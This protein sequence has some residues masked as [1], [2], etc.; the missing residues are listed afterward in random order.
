MPR[1]SSARRGA[2]TVLL[3]TV[4]LGVAGAEVG[5]RIMQ[6]IPSEKLLPFPSMTYLDGPSAETPTEGYTRF[7]PELGWSIG[8]SAQAVNDGIVFR[9]NEGGFRADRE[10]SLTPP[11]GIR[12]IAAF[13]DSFAHCDEVQYD[14][15]WTSEVEQAWAGTEVMNFGLPGGAPDQGWLRYRR[16]ALPYQPCA[17]IIGF[18]VENINRVVNRYRPFYAPQSGIALSKP[19]FVLDGDGLRLLPNPVTSASLLNDPAWVERSLGPDDFWYYPGMYA[20]G[21]FDDLLLGRVVRT[22]LYN[23]H[24]AAIRGAIDEGH[25]HGSAYQ[26]NDERFQVAGR[27]LTAFAHD[28]EGR[29][30]TPVVVFFGQRT[31][32]VS[33]RHKEPK[34]YRPLLDWLKG[35]GIATVDVTDDL[36]RAADK[37]GA[38]ALFA[39]G[40]HYNRRGNEVV[41]QALTAKLPNLVGA[42]CPGPAVAASR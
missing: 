32:V 12:R 9:S 5:L 19:R 27:L 29:G 4:V 24:R 2:L 17:A 6:P 30:A 15:C 21:P 18:Q 39:K 14:D 10:Y 28:V 41:G 8:R 23:E 22:A 42:T 20:P 7:D 35:E 26:P 11:P 31:E 36:A 25:P 37:V 38:D 40:G 34:E 33:V 16:D 1:G 3:I 13:G